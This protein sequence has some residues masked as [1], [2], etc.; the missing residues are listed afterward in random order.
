MLV[1]LELR[2]GALIVLLVP[3]DKTAAVLGCRLH[4]VVHGS[5]VRDWFLV[6]PLDL[7]CG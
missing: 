1:G 6:V 2:V 4:T 7:E 3:A 5:T